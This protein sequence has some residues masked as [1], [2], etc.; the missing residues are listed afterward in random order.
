MPLDVVRVIDS[1]TFALLDAADFKAAF[2]LWCK[3]WHQVPS[4][5]VPDDD[6]ILARFAGLSLAEWQGARGRILESWTLCDDGR[7]YHPV[8]AEKA[9]A[10]LIERLD[11]ALKGG[12]GNQR[13][14]GSA[15]DRDGLLDKRGDVVARL[16]RV[17]PSAKVKPAPGERKVTND[18]RRQ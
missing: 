17:N 11:A 7:F 6:R 3:A 12:A 4:G 15:F 9:L 13:R 16:L 2:A 10:A 8:V 1:D 14:W 5:S 18:R